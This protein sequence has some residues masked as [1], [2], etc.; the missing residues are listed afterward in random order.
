MDSLRTLVNRVFRSD[1]GDMFAEYPT[2]FDAEAPQGMRVVV[3]DGK[4]VSHVGVCVRDASI[5]GATVRTA[6]I[7]A[8]STYR[9]YRGRGFATQLM[10]DAI[11][12]ARGV[13]AHIMPISGGRG[14]YRRLGAISPGRFL[15]SKVPAHPSDSELSLRRATSADA[16]VLASLYQR[17]PIRFLRPLEDWRKLLRAEMLM[18]Q[19][20]DCWLIERGGRTAAYAATQRPQE[21]GLPR[22]QEYAGCRQ[23]LWE[24][25]GLLAGQYTANSVAMHLGPEDAQME[26][27]VRSLGL[28]PGVGTFG[29]TL[30]VLDVAR[31]LECLVPLWSER[32]GVGAVADLGLTADRESL[33]YQHGGQTVTLRGEE[34]TAALFGPEQGREAPGPLPGLEALPLPWYGYSYV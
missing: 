6:S 5:L 33:T 13:G 3:E 34:V 20:S 9:E 31:L 2:V 24:A 22:V 7:G 4:V 15:S 21:G 23:A 10:E 25:L 18:N 29:G 19:K 8:V 30:L 1:G 12:Y 27:R 14:L 16:P 26:T 17:E 28:E 11:A 32:H